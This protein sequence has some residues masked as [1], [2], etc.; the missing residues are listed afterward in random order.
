MGY[1]VGAACGL[2]ARENL[3][4]QEL[5]G[6]QVADWMHAQKLKTAKER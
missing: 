2:L 4:A 1:A 3:S 6:E 5:S